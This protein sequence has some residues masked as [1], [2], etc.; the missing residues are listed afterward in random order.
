MEHLLFCP[1]DS[2]LSGIHSVWNCQ[3]NKFCSIGTDMGC[4][5]IR[6]GQWALAMGRPQEP[7]C[8][9]ASVSSCWPHVTYRQPWSPLSAILDFQS[10]FQQVHHVWACQP[11]EAS[12]PSS[13][14]CSQHRLSGVH[15]KYLQTTKTKTRKSTKEGDIVLQIFPKSLLRG[16]DF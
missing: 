11:P 3:R 16:G 5:Q 10:A 6:A 2:A 15:P 9:R 14:H 8:T 4:V 13:T 7:R 12:W 1:K